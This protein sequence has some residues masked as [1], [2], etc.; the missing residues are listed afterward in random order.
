MKKLVYSLIIIALSYNALG[1]AMEPPIVRSNV[2]NRLR[3]AVRMLALQDSSYIKLIKALVD[4]CK[5][6]EANLPT[7]ESK[8]LWVVQDLLK[9]PL[10]QDQKYRNL[11]FLGILEISSFSKVQQVVLK[12]LLKEGWVDFV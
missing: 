12:G 10:M 7:F 9:S 3:S 6:Y 11:A 4:T 5:S 2:H 8:H 1:L